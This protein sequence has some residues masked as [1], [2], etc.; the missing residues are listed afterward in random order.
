MLHYCFTGDHWTFGNLRIDPS[1]RY[2]RKGSSEILA[3]QDRFPNR[4]NRGPRR[5]DPCYTQ[6]CQQFDWYESINR[7][8]ITTQPSSPIRG[9]WTFSMY[10]SW[11]A[12]RERRRLIATKKKRRWGRKLLNKL[13]FLQPAVVPKN[14]SDNYFLPWESSFECFF[15]FANSFLLDTTF[16]WSYATNRNGKRNNWLYP[17]RKNWGNC[18]SNDLSL[19]EKVK[20]Q[21]RNWISFYSSIK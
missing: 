11:S 1:N 12:R 5:P 3:V 8:T 9:G 6:A 4:F 20:Y 18:T 14:K 13:F 10:A 2:I 21:E 16:F 17:P 15:F 7:P 19:V